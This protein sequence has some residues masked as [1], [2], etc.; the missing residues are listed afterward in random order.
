MWS[1]R[2]R[3]HRASRMT[4]DGSAPCSWRPSKPCSRLSA[5]CACSAASPR[6]CPD[7]NA[8]VSSAA[9][10]CRSRVARQGGSCPGLAILIP[11]S[12]RLKPR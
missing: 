4:T 2:F 7:S 12:L 6:R 1:D 8:D 10:L 11:R 5:A 3:N 9:G